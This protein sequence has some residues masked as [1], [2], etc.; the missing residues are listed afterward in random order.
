MTNLP[1]QG[2]RIADFGQIIAIPFAAQI[3]GWLGAEVILVESSQHM[4]NRTLPPF[5]DGV[6]GV[7]RSAACNLMH[8]G[9]LSLVLNLR[10]PEGIDLAKRVISI[11]DVMMENFATGTIDRLG[12]GYETVRELRPD[13]IYLSLG[14]FGRSGPM[15]DFVGFHS[16]INA[17]S[18]LA[19]A[20]G[21]LGG[22][23]RILGG[24]FPDPLSGSYSILATLQALYHRSITGQ[25]QYIEIAM[26]EALTSIMPEAVADYTMNG[27]EAERVGNRD[28]DKAP[29]NLYRCNGTQKWVAI[30]VSTNAQWE[31]LCNAVGHPEWAS[32]SRFGDA[33]GR[34]ANQEFIDPLIEAWTRQ[35]EAYE[36]MVELQ[37]LGVPSAPALDSLELLQDP[38]LIDRDFVAW[39]DHPETGRRPIDNVAWKI[40][41]VRPTEYPRAP[42]LAEHNTYVL[43]ELLNLSKKEILRLT[44]AGAL[45]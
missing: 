15:K 40:D 35:R 39:V 19:A 11:S 23:P 4:S 36:V 41:G 33:A 7:N 18:G 20:T 8:S 37:R 30:S 43:E 45:V 31:S 2:V 9:K 25:G 24:I 21:Y 27:R 22:H 44:E 26:T 5:A 16:V 12:L 29:H 3:L 10:I 17:F 1:L 13:I 32:D 42:L 34:R 14:A 6:V 28:K 38:H